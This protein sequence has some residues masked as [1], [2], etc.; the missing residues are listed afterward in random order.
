MPHDI[1]VQ[2]SGGRLKR[3]AALRLKAVLA[4][5][6]TPRKLLLTLCIGGALGLLPIVWGTTILCVVVAYV[7]RLNQVALQSVNYLF[8]PLQLV[9]IIPYCRLGARLFPG[10]PPFPPGILTYVLHGHGAGMIQLFAW[11]T[12]KAV[13]AWLLTAPPLAFVLYLLFSMVIGGKRSSTSEAPQ[14]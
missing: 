4:A 9:L 8:Y 5:G 3:A 6:L 12:L 13:G 10:G 1:I 2:P 14:Q 11:A 7:F